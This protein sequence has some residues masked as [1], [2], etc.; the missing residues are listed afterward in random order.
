MFPTPFLR[1]LARPLVTALACITGTGTV[2]SQQQDTT[3][4][5]EDAARIKEVYQVVVQGDQRVQHGPYKI[6]YRNGNIW[7][8]GDFANG[9]LQGEWKTHFPEGGVQQ[10]LNYQAGLAQG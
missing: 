6:W 1:L 8:E 4:Y 3:Y 7:Q 5:P 9:K 2:L 10:R